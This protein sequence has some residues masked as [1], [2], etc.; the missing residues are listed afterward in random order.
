M[1][2]IITMDAEMIGCGDEEYRKLTQMSFVLCPFRLTIH[3]TL[4]ILSDA[5][6]PLQL[7]PQG[8]IDH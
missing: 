2:I 6:Q 5:N 7:T 3:N 8:Q 4:H 1:E